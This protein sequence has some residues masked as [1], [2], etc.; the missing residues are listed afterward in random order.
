MDAQPGEPGERHA[1]NLLVPKD[2][3]GLRREARIHAGTESGSKDPKHL[4]HVS[5]VQTSLSSWLSWV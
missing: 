1:L 3:T 5:V 2:A 4:G